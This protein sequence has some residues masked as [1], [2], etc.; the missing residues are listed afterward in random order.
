VSNIV[1]IITLFDPSPAFQYGQLSDGTFAILYGNQLARNS[2]VASA[3]FPNSE[4]PQYDLSGNLIFNPISSQINLPSNSYV[5]NLPSQVYGTP[6]G[7]DVYSVL[8]INSTLSRIEP[9]FSRLQVT[10]QYYD[11]ATSTYN[12]I[13]E[14]L[15]SPFFEG[16]DLTA[17]ELNNIVNYTEE[18]VA[19]LQKEI[20]I[21]T[22]EVKYS[23]SRELWRGTS[24]SGQLSVISAT[25]NLQNGPLIRSDFA[26]DLPTEDVEAKTVTPIPTY[27]ELESVAFNAGST[28][29]Y[30]QVSPGNAFGAGP[31]YFT[32]GSH[33]YPEFSYYLSEASDASGV[34]CVVVVLGADWGNFSGQSGISILSYRFD[35]TASGSNAVDRSVGTTSNKVY[36]DLIAQTWGTN[37]PTNSITPTTVGTVTTQFNTPAIPIPAGSEYVLVRESYGNAF[38]LNQDPV[39][40]YG[41]DNNSGAGVFSP[42]E[43]TAG[44]N[45]GIVASGY[46]GMQSAKADTVSYNGQNYPRIIFYPNASTTLITLNDISAIFMTDDSY[47][48]GGGG[49][50]DNPVLTVNKPITLTPM[51]PANGPTI[52]AASTPSVGC[53]GNAITVTGNYFNKTYD[54]AKVAGQPAA[55]NVLSNTVCTVTIPSVATG[56]TTLQ[57]T[58]GIHT[59]AS[60]PF[61]VNGQ[62]TITSVNPTQVAPG[63][64]VTIYGTNFGTQNANCSVWIAGNDT[65]INSWTNTSVI[66]TTPIF[67]LGPAQI[68]L[69]TACGESTNSN[70]SIAETDTVV[71]SPTVQTVPETTTFQF[72]ATLYLGTINDGDITTNSNTTWSVNGTVGGNAT[73]GTITQSGLYTAPPVQPPNTVTVTVAYLDLYENAVLSDSAT[74]TLTDQP[75]VTLSPA[76]VNLS[77]GQTQQYQVLLT[78]G[79]VQTDVTSSSTFF[80]NG[81]AGGELVDGTINAS[82]LYSA[83]NNLTEAVS[84]PIQARYVYE[85]NTLIANAVAIVAQTPT[86]FA[87]LTVI[88]QIN[89]FLGDGRFGYVPTGTQMIAYPNQYVYVQF[90]EQWD[91]Q[92]H[93]PVATYVPVQQLTMNAKNA[94]DSDIGNVIYNLADAAIQPDGT[95]LTLRTVVLGIIDPSDGRWHSMWDIANPVPGVSEMSGHDVEP[96]K[97]FGSDV[98]AFKDSHKFQGSLVDYINDM[99]GGAQS[100]LDFLVK[101]TNILLAGNCSYEEG[102]NKFKVLD[103]LYILGISGENSYGILGV[104]PKQE[105]TVVPNQYVYIDSNN[106]LQVGNFS[107]VFLEAQDPKTIFVGACLDR[108]YTHWPLLKLI[109]VDTSHVEDLGKNS[110]MRVGPLLVQWG[111]TESYKVSKKSATSNTIEFPVAFEKSCIVL[112]ES[113][114]SSGGFPVTQSEAIDKTSFEVKLIN[115]G[116]TNVSS[117]VSWIAL[118]Y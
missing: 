24:V 102:T 33:T 98:K 95:T 62:P 43:A 77:S 96:S 23:L 48:S 59:P 14:Y 8:Q 87:S 72:T 116:S 36:F 91:N 80:V 82:G 50:T 71:I 100:Q 21:L 117:Q 70:F 114:N 90:Q 110:Y 51:L 2:E 85:S 58:D 1:S 111:S 109:D 101:R 94:L 92:F 37:T 112:T 64:Q 45:N 53:I 76:N 7:N 63:S 78:I 12:T 81:N 41:P 15:D 27:T 13:S 103:N 4:I 17:Q 107:D 115:T 86:A 26:H 47:N 73:Y 31:F 105:I 99:S 18:A 56:P 79:G 118:G 106:K 9:G 69:I 83:P 35:F 22:Q 39:W 52:N 19:F 68:V 30:S 88:S 10:Y 29:S 93:L 3:G 84:E 66:V 6:P 89:V 38:Y 67:V 104:I 46:T 57:I 40:F 20:D 44:S 54:S 32:G 74:V 5:L 108:F 65:T 113:K 11:N 28:G 75:I 16:W 60:I 55:I 42:P 49:F 61:T 97:L 25:E 34:M